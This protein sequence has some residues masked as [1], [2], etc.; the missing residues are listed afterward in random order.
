MA[1]KGFYIMGSFQKGKKAFPYFDIKKPFEIDTQRG[2]VTPCVF[3]FWKE[4]IWFDEWEF[5]EGHKLSDLKS[6]NNLKE[7][8]NSIWEDWCKK[9]NRKYKVIFEV[10]K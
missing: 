5:L 2:E 9:H 4:N 10:S 6:D 8:C 7:F 1:L 3:H